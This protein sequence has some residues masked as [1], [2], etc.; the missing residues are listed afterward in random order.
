MLAPIACEVRDFNE[1][2]KSTLQFQL[3]L[4]HTTL[5]T[6][7]SECHPHN[8]R[9]LISMRASQLKIQHFPRLNNDNYL[10]TKP[11]NV[12]SVEEH[13]WCKSCKFVCKCQD[14]Q[15]ILKKT[16]FNARFIIKK[17]VLYAFQTKRTTLFS[18]RPHV[19]PGHQSR[20]T[21]VEIKKIS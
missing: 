4:L 9:L 11:A 14:F 20:V 18:S 5:E 7:N 8:N 3:F 2:V 15:N 21:K 1:D 10:K 6:G 12:F 13:E 16:G 19:T 17:T